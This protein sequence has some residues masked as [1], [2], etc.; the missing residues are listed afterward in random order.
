M[1]QGTIV[2][3]GAS[4]GIGEAC[5]LHFDKK[6][7]RVFA[8]VRKAS[9]GEALRQKTS[10]R[11]TPLIMDVTDQASVAAA[12]NSIDR[13][14]ISG[15]V[16]NA[17]IAISAPVELIPL[18]KLREQLEVNVI[19]QVGVIQAFLPLLRQGRGRIV[20][21]SSVAGRSV[22]PFTGA[23]SASKHAI[24]AIS[25]ALRMEL[26]EWAIHV[27]IIEPGAVKTPIW[28]K[29]VQRANDMIAQFPDEGL[30]L[31]RYLI[32]KMIAAAAQASHRGVDPSEVVKAV[33]HALLD[34]K[35]KI[36]YVVGKDAKMR[37]L[38]NYLP[39]KMRDNM[40]MKRI[41]AIKT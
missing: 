23:Y 20:N 35:P 31:Y 34:A 7:F 11:L 33:D 2:I 16:N 18:D 40:I 14:E 6:G 30:D 26:R 29:G 36:R 25:D 3:T 1:A 37:M 15:L 41:N 28:D 17:G 32:A 24:E 10:D 22:L 39:D 19:G 21:I 38:V 12:A 8:G 13:K 5:A 4:S 9:D 27:A